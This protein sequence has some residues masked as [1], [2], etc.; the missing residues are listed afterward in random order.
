M[1]NLCIGD[2]AYLRT[3]ENG[4]NFGIVIAKLDGMVRLDL[5]D[6]RQASFFYNELF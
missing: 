1:R 2:T 5:P 6:N 4:C 3:P